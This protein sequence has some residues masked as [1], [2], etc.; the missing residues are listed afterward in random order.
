LADV[1]AEMIRL[2]D[3][4]RLAYAEYGAPLG[5][6]VF[7]FQGTPSSRLMHPDEGV[8][9]DLGVRLIVA[10]RPGFGLS[11]LQPGRT[12]LDWPDDVAELANA[13]GIDR[14]G[15]VGVSGGGPY[16]LACAYKLPH[17][18]TAVAIAGGSG[19]VDETANL[20]GSARERHIGYILARR[21]PWLLRLVI[22]LARN[23]QRNP[24]RFQ[25]QFSA[26]AAG[27]DRAIME[28]PA[29]KEMFINSYTEATRQGVRAF[30]DEVTLA[31]K[32]WGFPLQDIRIPV[33]LWHGEEDRSTP[34]AMARAIAAAIQDCRTTFLPGEGHLFLFDRWAEILADLLVTSE[35]RTA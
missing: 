8:T 10:D 21:A 17:R 15:I 2:P 19:P 13:L 16:T 27:A 1:V 9:R 14:F 29:I 31:S 28:R 7:F 4:R 33:H 25:A 30:A 34:I 22:A 24:A 20:E 11:D 23:P 32:P 35:G 3:G 26:G 6:P 5:Q 12:L 18:L